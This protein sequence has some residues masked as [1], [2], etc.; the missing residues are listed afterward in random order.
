MM[1]GKGDYENVTETALLQ[2]SL[3]MWSGL[4]HPKIQ[5]TNI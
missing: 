1:R 4:N 2:Q 3:M 5:N